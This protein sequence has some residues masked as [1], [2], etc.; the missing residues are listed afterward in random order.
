MKEIWF[1]LGAFADLLCGRDAL[2]AE[3]ALLRQQLIVARRKIVGRV[4]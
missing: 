3:T 1:V 4:R 2:V